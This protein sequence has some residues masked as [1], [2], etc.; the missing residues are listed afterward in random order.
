MRLPTRKLALERITSGALNDVL[1]G[2]DT[3]SNR[4]FRALRQRCRHDSKL[5]FG[6]F[7]SE[8]FLIA[9]VRLCRA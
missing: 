5:E 6:G 4:S 9:I 2:L 3:A 8:I 1:N 7:E